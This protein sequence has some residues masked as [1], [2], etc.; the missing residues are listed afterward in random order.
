[1]KLAL[2]NWE[3]KE[4]FIELV[5]DWFQETT[6]S[7]SARIYRFCAAFADGDTDVIQEMLHEYLWDSISVRDTAVR[8]SLK[9]NFHPKG[10]PSVYHGMLLGLLRSQENWVIRSNAETG[11][12]YSDISIC[13]PERIGMVIEVKYAEDGNLEAACA[14]AL[15]QIEARKYATGLQRRGMKKILK[16][17]LAFFGKECKVAMAADSKSLELGCDQ[18][19]EGTS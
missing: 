17:G 6:L 18:R 10:V 14:K 12:G 13:T 9:E 7:D 15:K 8:R 4:L 11:E 19:K 3:I 2:P 16:Y 5:K 1:M